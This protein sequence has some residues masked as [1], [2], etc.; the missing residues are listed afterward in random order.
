MYGILMC[1]TNTDTFVSLI[2][3]YL[4]VREYILFWSVHSPIVGRYLKVLEKFATEKGT[5]LRTI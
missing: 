2:Y 3:H 5:G 1:S 4:E